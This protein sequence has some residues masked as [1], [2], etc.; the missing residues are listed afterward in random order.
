MRIV[1]IGAGA[2]GGWLAGV[3]AR[4]GAE[5]GLVARGAT[6]AAIR[7]DGLTLIESERRETFAAV[8]ESAVDYR[9]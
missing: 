2:V 8:S 7:A 3:L 5:V 4:G 1:V 6:L 9:A